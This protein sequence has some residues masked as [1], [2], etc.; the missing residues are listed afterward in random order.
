[1]EDSYTLACS[2]AAGALPTLSLNFNEA[3]TFNPIRCSSTYTVTPSVFVDGVAVAAST[4]ALQWQIKDASTTAWRALAATDTGLSVSSDSKTL[5]ITPKQFYGPATLRVRAD[6]DMNGSPSTANLT[7]ASPE[8][9]L[10]ITRRIP[11]FEA[12][13]QA[14]T[15]IATGTEEVYASVELYD[16]QGTITE[17]AKGILLPMWY[18]AKDQSNGSPSLTTFLADGYEAKIPTTYMDQQYGM[19]TGVEVLDVQPVQIMA[20]S[21]GQYI[22]DSDGQIILI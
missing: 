6:Y 11:D 14:P 8:K 12:D 5:T 1:V 16:N 7:D 15:A 21:D 20:D 9:V 18:V 17:A 10:T 2:S 19:M 13:I 4:F 3:F 22:T